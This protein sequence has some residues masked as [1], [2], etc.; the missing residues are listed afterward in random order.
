MCVCVCGSVSAFRGDSLRAHRLVYLGNTSLFS[1]GDFPLCCQAFSKSADRSCF[2]LGGGVLVFAG[3]FE[4][5]GH[6]RPFRKEALVEL[7]YCRGSLEAIRALF[8]PVQGGILTRVG[9]CFLPS[10]LPVKVSKLVTWRPAFS[11]KRLPVVS[12]PLL[13]VTIQSNTME[14]DH[15]PDWCKHNGVL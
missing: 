9:V 8:C 13:S 1:E 6:I 12:T 2:F 14:L 15:D 3:A 5:L 11:M 7:F 4:V 10:L